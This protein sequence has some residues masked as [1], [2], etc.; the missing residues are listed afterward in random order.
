MHESIFQRA[1][2]R[3]EESQLIL[4]FVSYF[5]CSGV[6]YMHPDLKF[7]YVSVKVIGC[8]KLK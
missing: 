1:E 2:K 3:G 6:D 4:L 5:Y 7:N 8:M